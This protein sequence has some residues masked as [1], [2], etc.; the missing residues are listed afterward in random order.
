[1]MTK[2]LV[3]DDDRDLVES[4]KEILEHAGHEVACA[5]DGDEGF[6]LAKE[7]KPD[8]IVLDVMMS[9]DTEGFETV[10]RLRAEKATQELPIIMLTGIRRAKRLPF[11]FE[12]DPE[13]LPVVAVLEKPVKPEQLLKLVEEAR[14]SCVRCGGS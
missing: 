10:K 3:V 9:H 5:Y 4:T 2:V 14:G 13:W 7:W 1:M 11:R 12:P 8:V 6:R